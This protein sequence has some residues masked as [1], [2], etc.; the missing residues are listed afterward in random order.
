MRKTIL[1]LF[2]V[3]GQFGLG[4]QQELTENTWYLTEI[5]IAGEVFYPPQNEEVPFVTMGIDCDPD[6]ESMCWFHSEFCDTL[7]GL[8]TWINNYQFFIL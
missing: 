2:L 3:I 4:Q 7:G 8:L 6:P 5:N 1:L